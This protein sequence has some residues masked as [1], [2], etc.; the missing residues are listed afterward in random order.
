MYSLDLL[1]QQIRSYVIQSI[2]MT[3][4]EIKHENEVGEDIN[5]FDV[6]GK[7]SRK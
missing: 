6:T 2:D 5:V 4:T 3:S 1:V 7:S